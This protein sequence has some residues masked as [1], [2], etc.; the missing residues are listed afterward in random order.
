MNDDDLVT[1]APA[2]AL[3]V[4]KGDYRKGTKIPYFDG[5]LERRCC[6]VGSGDALEC[7]LACSAV[8]WPR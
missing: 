4:H 3:E 2:L 1:R 6:V 8:R 5:H 7:E